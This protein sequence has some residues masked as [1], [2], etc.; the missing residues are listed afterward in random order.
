MG[1]LCAFV[2]FS[3]REVCVQ[4]Y[5]SSNRMTK[6]REITVMWQGPFSGWLEIGY[7]IRWDVVG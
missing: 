3:I 7:G 5:A 1:E 6:E 2:I 4:T